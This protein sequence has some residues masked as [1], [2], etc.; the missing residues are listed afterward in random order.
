MSSWLGTVQTEEE[1]VY[2][3]TI[4]ATLHA[5]TVLFILYSRAKRP[6]CGLVHGI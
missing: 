3:K 1:K 5:P 2:V 6:V 4:T